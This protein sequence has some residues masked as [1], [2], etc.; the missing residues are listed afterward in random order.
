MNLSPATHGV[1]AVLGDPVLAVGVATRMVVAVAAGGIPL[2]G[3]LP[4]RARM[5]VALALAAVAWPAALA[6]G[7]SSGDAAGVVLREAVTGLALGLAVAVMVAAAAWAGSVLGSVTGLSWSG[8]FGPISAEG[9]DD[10][11]GMGRLAWWLGLAGFFAAGGHLAVVATLV[12]SVRVLPVGSLPSG[13]VASMPVRLLAAASDIALMVAAPALVA[14]VVFHAATALCLRTVRFM[15]GQ[16]LLQAAAALL[17]LA[18]L[19]LGGETWLSGFGGLAR[20]GVAA[21]LPGREK[22]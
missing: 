22:P 8:D 4:L 13:D 16:G 21:V 3:Q 10:A 2:G 12:D 19:W 18:A 6:M 15:P 1:L 9:G 5:V 20:D 11:A 14:V 7:P 17:L